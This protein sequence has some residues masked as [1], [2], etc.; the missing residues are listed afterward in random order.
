MVIEASSLH[1][2][3]SGDFDQ[4]RRRIAFLTKRLCGGVQYSRAAYVGFTL[5]GRHECS[6][7]ACLVVMV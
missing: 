3:G 5:L 7:K 6:I 4:G 1:I 2:G